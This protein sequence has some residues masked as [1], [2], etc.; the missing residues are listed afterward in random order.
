MQ[1][2]RLRT[3]DLNQTGRPFPEVN[4]FTALHIQ[5]VVAEEAGT[6]NKKTA[7]QIHAKDDKGNDYL[8]AMTADMFMTLAAGIKGARERWG[9]PHI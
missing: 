6:A 5:T 8:L 9:D 7:V 4:E 1:Q 2:I 3:Y